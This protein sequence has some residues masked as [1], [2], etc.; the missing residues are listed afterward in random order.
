[1]NKQIEEMAKIVS[2]NCGECYTCK[3]LGKATN[4]IDC[5]DFL[6]AN[7][8]YEQGY[9]KIDKDTL[10]IPKEL[11]YYTDIKKGVTYY[12]L[13]NANISFTEQQIIAMAQ[14]TH[15]MEKNIVEVVRKETAKEILQRF[16]NYLPPKEKD[17]FEIKTS[18][19]KDVKKAVLQFH[20]SLNDD[21]VEFAKQY[22]V[23]IE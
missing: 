12:V 14:I 13:D 5:T 10:I 4:N 17:S 20:N 22:G 19:L 15:S 23:E 9:R 1:M 21:I 18:S 8:L 11:S 2:M 7:E 6:I 16:Y 3:F